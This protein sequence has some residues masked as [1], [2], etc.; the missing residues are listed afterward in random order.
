MNRRL[1]TRLTT[2]A[3]LTIPARAIAQTMRT[4]VRVGTIAIDNGAEVFYA[5][6][7]GLFEKAGLSVEITT[8]S[9]GGAIVAAV[10]SG[11]LDVGFSNL[12]SVVAAFARGIPVRVIAPASLYLNT[13][14]A[15]A[16]IV[17]KDSPYH[18]GKDL[19][20]KTV[21][22]DGLKGIS[23]ITAEAWIDAHGGDSKS[24]KFIEVPLPLMAQALLQHRIDAGNGALST[25]PTLGTPQ[26]TDRILGY[27]ND[28]VSKRFLTSG[29]ISNVSWINANG[30][31]V[32]RFGDATLE[33]GRWANANQTASGKILMK[34]GKL[35]P[36]LMRVLSHFRAPYAED[37]D[38]ALIAPVIAFS[39]R[40]GIIANAFPPEDLVA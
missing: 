13:S 27:P 35:T 30:D 4:T 19:D 36:T 11:A 34:Y 20:G 23:Q 8:M 40:Y 2:G 7:R 29:W 31:A 39:V 33:A 5:Q 15:Q 21:G 10:A 18:T 38:P 12:F 6:D 3:V 25:D 24:V 9:N 37:L 1:F 14:P 32:R 26:A 17:L 22:C 28:A 16:L